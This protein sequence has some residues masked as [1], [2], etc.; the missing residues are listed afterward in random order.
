MVRILVP[1]NQ[2]K[3]KRPKIFECDFCGCVFE[4]DRTEYV[5]EQ[6]TEF[7]RY[8]CECPCCGMYPTEKP[9]VTG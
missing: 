5:Y 7:D 9:R 4:A 8:V 2:K 6:Y 1:G 3:S